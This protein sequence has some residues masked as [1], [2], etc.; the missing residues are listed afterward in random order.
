MVI[1]SYL[2]I[3]AIAGFVAGLFGVGGGL[4]IVP[5]LIFAFSLKGFS[6]EVLTHIAI[7]TSLATIV[8]TSISSVIAHHRAGAVLWSI[9]KVI[10]P[11]IFVG[12][13]LGGQLAAVL[14]GIELQLLLGVFILFV[15]AQ[16]GFG[17]KA[18][19]QR[20]V[21]GLVG[22][23]I[24]G[25][26]IGGISALFG[27]G[28]GSIT[29]PFLSF[30]NVKMQ[31]AVASSA[32]VG[33]PIAVAGALSS[34]WAGFGHADLPEYSTGYVYWPA[35]FGIVVASAALAPIGAKLAH[36]LPAEKLQKFFALFLFLIGAQFIIRSWS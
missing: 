1:I 3:G 29:V 27:I 10:T 8:V 36:R 2:A 21:P 11:S 15:A 32:A 33:L 30:C 23:S 24:S 26:A 6:P 18:S 7:A 20:N 5:I 17:I 13:W 22:L 28:G 34:M 4:I 16:M 35:F 14:S 9:V 31:Q 25:A 19:A 12:A